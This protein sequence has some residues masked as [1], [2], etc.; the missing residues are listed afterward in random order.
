M[1]VLDSDGE[2]LA[3]FTLNPTKTYQTQKRPGQHP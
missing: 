3:E 1:L 2:L